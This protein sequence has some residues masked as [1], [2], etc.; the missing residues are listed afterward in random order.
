MKKILIAEDDPPSSDLLF[1]LLTAKGYDVVQSADGAEAV[2]KIEQF[3]PDLI[4]LDIQM[5]VLDGFAVLRW[6]R[7]HPRFAYLPVAALTAYAM[8]EDRQRILAAGFDAHIS[9]PIDL[10]VLSVQVEGLLK[11][12]AQ[13]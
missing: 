6:V 13:E 4:L 2:G 12:T 3:A 1:E 9:K 5:P 7:Q 11:K 8:L 10:A